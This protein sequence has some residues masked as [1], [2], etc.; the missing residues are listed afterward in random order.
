MGWKSYLPLD[1]DAGEGF[2]ARLF[3]PLSGFGSQ[4]DDGTI[5]VLEKVLASMVKNELRRLDICLKIELLSHEAKGH[6]LLIPRE[7]LAW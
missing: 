3:E 7:K 1:I 2:G 6:I 4:K 5:P